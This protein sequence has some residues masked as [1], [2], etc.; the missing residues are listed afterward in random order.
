[1]EEKKSTFLTKL[2]TSQEYNKEY[3][4]TI[5]DYLVYDS[6]LVGPIVVPKN[7]VY[8]KNSIPWYLRWVFPVSGRKS[9]YAA[10]VH[11]WLYITELFPRVVCDCIYL[12]AMKVSGVSNFRAKAKY[13]AVD[14]LGWTVWNKHTKKSIDF[15]RSFVIIKEMEKV[16]KE[17]GFAPTA[18]EMWNLS[19]YPARLGAI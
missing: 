3:R 13:F 15:G 18:Y 6:E 12:E 16:L 4:W 14:K 5:E 10:T 9:D 11:D 17:H 8:D 19:R 2:N 7:F 1:M